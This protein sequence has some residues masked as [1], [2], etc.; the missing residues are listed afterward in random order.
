M[1]CTEG[2]EQGHEVWQDRNSLSGYGETS[3]HHDLDV[4][5]DAESLA[6]KLPTY[7]IEWTGRSRPLC[8]HATLISS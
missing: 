6:S 2:A 5:L 8:C 3:Q 1:M 7:R 4:L